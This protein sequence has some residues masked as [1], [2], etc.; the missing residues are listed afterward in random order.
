MTMHPPFSGPAAIPLA[1]ESAAI[2]AAPAYDTAAARRYLADMPKIRALIDSLPEDDGLTCFGQS[3]PSAAALQRLE[4]E[5]RRISAEGH[6]VSLI[7]ADPVTKSGISFRSAVPM[8]TQSTVKAIYVG[9]LLNSC[10]QA[11]AENGQYV[12]DTIVLSSNEAYESLRE[13]YG[14]E[15]IRAWC[16]ETGVDEHFADL[17]YPRTY[18]ARDMLKLWTRLYCFLNDGSD[19][20]NAGRYFADSAMSAAKERLGDRCPVQTKAGWEN[21]V[22]DEPED[23]AHAVI[24]ERYRDGDPTNDECATNDTGVV[25]TERGPYL[26]VIH[27]DYPCPWSVPNQLYGLTEALYAAMTKRQEDSSLRSE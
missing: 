17:P 24:P 8:C 16:R 4:A 26:F 2:Q 10:P 9:A 3:V 7:M 14:P 25:Y 23:Y 19:T 21:G 6:Q 22:G 5:I 15:P 27:S 18:T 13:I 20:A 1:E 12:R 11:F